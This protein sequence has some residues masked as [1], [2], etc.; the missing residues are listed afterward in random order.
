MVF[1]NVGY[2]SNNK[3]KY[4]I[5]RAS[6]KTWTR[7]LDLDPE[8]PGLGKTQ[9]LENMDPEKHR[10]NTGLKYMSDFRDLLFFEWAKIQIFGILQILHKIVGDRNFGPIIYF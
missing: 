4:R 6:S 10:I 5:F 9:T 8:K 7:T 1:M 2:Q 3:S